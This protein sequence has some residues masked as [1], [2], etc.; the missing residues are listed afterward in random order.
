VPDEKTSIRSALIGA[1]AA[2]LVACIGYLGVTNNSKKPPEPAVVTGRVTDLEGNSIAK[3]AVKVAFG[4]TSDARR[5]D[6]CFA[7]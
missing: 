6:G 5:S 1:G 7:M 2:I 4:A 3:A